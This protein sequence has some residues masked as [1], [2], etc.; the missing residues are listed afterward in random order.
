M[1]LGKSALFPHPKTFKP[2]AKA[3]RANSYTDE[4]LEELFSS[5][6]KSDRM[7]APTLNKS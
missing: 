4:R 1:W 7:L 3:S 2:F 5:S 6:L